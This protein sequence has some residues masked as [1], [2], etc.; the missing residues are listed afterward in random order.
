M[1]L[2]SHRHTPEI[3][4]QLGYAANETVKIELHTASG[5]DE[6]GKFW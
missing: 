4:E 2:E 1:Q 5:S 6:P 3:E